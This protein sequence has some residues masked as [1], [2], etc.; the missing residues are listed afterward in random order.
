MKKLQQQVGPLPTKAP[1]P[2]LVI[3]RTFY[4]L[5]KNPEVMKKLQQ[6]VG[7]LPEQA[8]TLAFRSRCGHGG[9][10]GFAVLSLVLAGN[11]V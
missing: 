10:G 5:M 4:E 1:S 6:Q 3:P 9:A 11:Q 7:P 2:L 8:T